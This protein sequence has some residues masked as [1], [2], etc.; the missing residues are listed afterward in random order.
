MSV[1]QLIIPFGIIA[2]LSVLLSGLT[3]ARII[4]LKLVWHKRIALLTIILATIHAAFVLS[5]TNF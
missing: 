5:V 2:Y 4:K 3:G 1:Y